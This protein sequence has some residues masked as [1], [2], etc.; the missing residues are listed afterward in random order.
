MSS[1]SSNL[2]HDSGTSP[3]NSVIS[4][5]GGGVQKGRHHLPDLRTTLD[6]LIAYASS[7]EDNDSPVSGSFSPGST[8]EEDEERAEAKSNRKVRSISSPTSSFFENIAPSIQMADLEITN[9]S[10]LAINASLEKTKTRQAQEIRELR[11]KL[12]ETRLMLPPL[13]YRAVKSSQ[14][15]TEVGDDEEDV[16]SDNVSSSEENDRIHSADQGTGAGAGTGHEKDTTSATYRRIKLIIETLLETG[17]KA[18]EKTK[19]DFIDSRGGAKVLTAEEVESWRDSGAAS[20][21][22]GRF[23]DSESHL[24]DD[25]D[26]SCPYSGYLTPSRSPTPL[27]DST[28][29]SVIR[30][31]SHS[32]QPNS[33]LSSSSTVKLLSSPKLPP[34]LITETP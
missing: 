10:L 14:D 24:D 30:P 32:R 9:R 4:G 3:E 7:R 18:L 5:G 21:T 20:S 15:P 28:S 12:R 34:I 33:G 6:N 11:R 22:V 19:Q 1:R 8:A 31:G 29:E 16:D 13:T 25:E 17:Q 27:L 26:A 23:S 2:T